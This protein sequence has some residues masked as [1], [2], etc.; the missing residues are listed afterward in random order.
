[1]CGGGGVGLVGGCHCIFTPVC[2]ATKYQSSL[3]RL[4]ARRVFST[5]D[6]NK[7]II[8]FVPQAAATR[9]ASG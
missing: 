2:C 5:M 4:T 8:E 3:T 7:I 1:V 9:R 6:I